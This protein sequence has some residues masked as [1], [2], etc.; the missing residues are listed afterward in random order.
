M[1]IC[2]RCSA[3]LKAYTATGSVWQC[4]TCGVTYP[5]KELLADKTSL[6]AIS[7]EQLTLSSLNSSF[8]LPTSSR[9]T[10]KTSVKKS[11]GL[12]CAVMKAFDFIQRGNSEGYTSIEFKYADCYF[13][14]AKLKEKS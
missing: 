12:E 6:T 5:L 8:N 3:A 14:I 7:P 1:L 2:P 11:E 13:V 9:K 4:I 10:L